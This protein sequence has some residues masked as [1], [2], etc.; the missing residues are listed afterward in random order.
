MATP[1][2]TTRL[3]ESHGEL[4]GEELAKRDALV[5]LGR[6]SDAFDVAHA[7]LFLTRLTM[8]VRVLNH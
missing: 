1:R 7:V 6:R 2:I 8:D 3:R 5:P 4:F